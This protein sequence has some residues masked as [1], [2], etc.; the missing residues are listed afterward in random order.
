[1]GWSRDAKLVWCL[2]PT[3]FECKDHSLVNSG[4]EANEVIIFHDLSEL[5]VALVLVST[6]EEFYVSWS[7]LHVLITTNLYT[8]NSINVF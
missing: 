3:G 2:F 8:W 5:Q 4:P 7:Q 1:M 6:T